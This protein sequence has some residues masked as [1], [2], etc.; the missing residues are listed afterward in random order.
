MPDS[1][2]GKPFPALD[3]LPSGCKE[4]AVRNAQ[5]LRA[6]KKSMEPH[7]CHLHKNNDQF[8]MINMT[9]KVLM[10]RRIRS[11]RKKKKKKKNLKAV[12]GGDGEKKNLKAV[13][14][15]DGEKIHTV[16]IIINS[17]A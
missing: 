16:I 3:F 14:G 5:R 2:S 4:A 17:R 7:H 9:H 12:W 8:E 11:R 1:I 10:R 15:G 13:W 6:V